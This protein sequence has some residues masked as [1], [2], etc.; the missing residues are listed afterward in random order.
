M[1]NILELVSEAALEKFKSE[2]KRIISLFLF[3]HKRGSKMEL[4]AIHH[5]STEG[6]SIFNHLI[7]L[8]QAI[9]IHR[10]L[11]SATWSLSFNMREFRILRPLSELSVIQVLKN[12]HY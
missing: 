7:H 4:I 5:S 11:N 3:V 2:N 12:Y 6:K 10:K 1:R 8:T 9:Q